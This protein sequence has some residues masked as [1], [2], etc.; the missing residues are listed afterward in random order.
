MKQATLNLGQG[1]HTMGQKTY[2][3]HFISG[4]TGLSMYTGEYRFRNRIRMAQERYSLRYG[5]HLSLKILDKATLTE[6]QYM[7]VPKEIAGWKCP[8][9]KT[10]LQRTQVAWICEQC[11]FSKAIKNLTRELLE[12]K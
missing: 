8:F 6:V 7:D 10:R 2:I 12:G 9:C 1:G 11:G 5:A 3:V 4:I